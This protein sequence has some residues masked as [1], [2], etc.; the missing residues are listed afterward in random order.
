[1]ADEVITCLKEPCPKEEEKPKPKESGLDELEDIGKDLG[2]LAGEEEEVGDD[3]ALASV[4]C[5]PECGAAV[6]AIGTVAV[7]GVGLGSAAKDA[8]D[9]FKH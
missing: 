4:I 8:W 3:I 5:G 6:G 9:Y 1:M 2:E 7:L